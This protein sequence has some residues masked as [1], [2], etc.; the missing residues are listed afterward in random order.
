MRISATQ[1]AQNETRIRAAMDRL[2]DGQIPPGGKC[3]VKTLAREVNVDRTAFY[4]ARP[5]AHLRE[6][7][8]QRLQALHAAGEVPDPA[9]PRSSA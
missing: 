7:F 5:Y 4:S 6:E 3:D 1:R 2:L 8:E 9:T